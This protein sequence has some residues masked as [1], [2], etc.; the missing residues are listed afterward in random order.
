VASRRLSEARE[1]QEDVGVVRVEYVIVLDNVRADALG[2]SGSAFGSAIVDGF[3]TKAN[4]GNDVAGVF[5]LEVLDAPQPIEYSS[6][7]GIILPTTTTTTTT[8]TTS[9][10]TS[11]TSTT[12]TTLPHLHVDD[13]SGSPVAPAVM[14]VLTLILSVS[15]L[16]CAIGRY[17]VV[18]LRRP[19]HGIARIKRLVGCKED[20]QVA[21]DVS[22]TPNEDPEDE[23]P[24]IVWNVDVD[25]ITALNALEAVMDR[26][27]SDGSL[28]SASPSRKGAVRQAPRMR[29]DV[30]VSPG[31]VKSRAASAWH[32]QDH[33]DVDV[34]LHDGGEDVLDELMTPMYTENEVIEYYSRTHGRWMPGRIA[35]A[36]RPATMVRESDFVYNIIV[37]SGGRSQ[38]R[39]GTPLPY[40]R[41]P[42]D[43]GEVV[44]ARSSLHGGRWVEAVVEPVPQR[45]QKLT[46]RVVEDG[47]LLENILNSKVRRF[48]RQGD[49]VCA[50]QGAMAG[51]VDG[52]VDGEAFVAA[53]TDFGSP[54]A[55]VLPSVA[56]AQSQASGATSAF[57]SPVSAANASTGSSPHAA[58]DA[59]GSPA[60]AGGRVA[61]RLSG[62][63]RVVWVPHH[64]LYAVSPEMEI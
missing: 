51:W 4:E 8:T 19:T 13:K 60:V 35:L 23:R 58:G 14:G 9:T 57:S 62:E 42:L 32:N 6:V 59:D 33:Q 5:F 61:V 50:Y 48:F 53:D 34:L 22:K 64:L 21:W 7:D 12:T 17:C 55:S 18:S 16:C 43:S 40:I 26:R 38:R 37:H 41:R 44:E 27:P 45:F 63:D 52:I 10:T 29:F 49:F 47:A 24:R 3:V 2:I 15:C 56:S 36:T 28:R 46:V 30:A 25:A 20:M 31:H 1:L 54:A 11:T 39:D